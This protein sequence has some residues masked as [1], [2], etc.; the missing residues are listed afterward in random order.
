MDR[1]WLVCGDGFLGEEFRKHLRTLTVSESLSHSLKYTH[2]TT[3]ESQDDLVKL[4]RVLKPRYILNASGPS[5]VNDSYSNA[6]YYETQPLDLVKAHI[7]LMNDL[8]DPPVYIYL[9][10]G[11]IYG[12]TVIGGAAEHASPKPISPYGVGKVNAENFLLSL[13]TLGFKVVIL[14]VFSSYSNELK[15]RLPFVIR[16]KF[17]QNNEIELSGTGNELRDFVHTSDLVSAASMIVSNRAHAQSPV[18]NI[19]SGL[20]LSVEEIVQIAANEYTKRSNGAIHSFGFNNKVRPYDPRVLLPDISKLKMLG[21]IPQVHPKVGLA[22]YF[23]Q[24]DIGD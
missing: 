6:S 20:A 18:W 10:S 11:A 3:R 2:R 19:G 15:S 17:N 22:S 7:Q 14:R 13:E 4:V 5:N 23:G 12:E 9:S 1:E 16:Q 21:F 24:V 8:D